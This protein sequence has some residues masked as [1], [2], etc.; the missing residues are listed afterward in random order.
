MVRKYLPVA[1]LSLLGIGMAVLAVWYLVNPI[2][3]A[4]VKRDILAFG[5]WAPM[6]FVLT[7]SLSNILPPLSTIIFWIIGIV[8]FG[9]FWAFVYSLAAN[10]IGN[11]SSYWFTRVWGRKLIYK[12]AGQSMLSRI[13]KYAKITKPRNLILLKIFSG[14]MT[15]YVGYGAGLARIKY[16]TFLWTNTLGAV[17]M[18]VF[19]F[20]ILSAG[21]NYN[22]ATT[23]AAIAVFYT[24]SYAMTIFLVP[25]VLLLRSKAGPGR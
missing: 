12:F 7:T 11:S 20:A 17:P 1:L 23:S 8:L 14:A 24:I 13:N 9:P 18:M 15:D 25:Q 16:T 3:T 19:G 2:N 6:F 22:L 4:D 5:P 21:L 10:I